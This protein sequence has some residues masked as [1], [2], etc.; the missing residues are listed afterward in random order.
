MS[1]ANNNGFLYFIS[2]VLLIAVLF[3][4]YALFT[5]DDNQTVVETVVEKVQPSD[6]GFNL[7]ITDDGFKASTQN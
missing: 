7:E 5:K 6:S 3:M 1:Q 2:G 4:G